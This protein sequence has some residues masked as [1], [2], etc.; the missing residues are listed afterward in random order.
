MP[1]SVI[2]KLHRLEN[3]HELSHDH[4][5]EYPAIASPFQHEQ[6]QNQLDSISPQDATIEEVKNTNHHDF[7]HPHTPSSMFYLPLDCHDAMTIFPGTITFHV[8]LLVLLVF[9]RYFIISLF[10]QLRQTKTNTSNNAPTDHTSITTIHIYTDSE[11][12]PKVEYRPHPKGEFRV[13]S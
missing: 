9:V 7:Q 3:H 13:V 12:N 8:A 2:R 5:H 11:Q 6:V 1:S 10:R 4:T